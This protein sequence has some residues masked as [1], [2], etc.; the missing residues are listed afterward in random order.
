MEST[1]YHYSARP[2]RNPF[3][4]LRAVWRLVRNDPSTQIEEAAIVEM[5]F[6]NSRLGRRFARWEGVVD[7]L[8]ADPRTAPSFSTRKPFERI[9]LEDLERLPEG[10]LG[11]VFADHCRA[12]ELDPNLVYM[13]PNDDVGWL[14]HH[15][16]HTHDI[17]HVFT[18][19]GNDLPGEFGLGGFYAAQLGSPPFFGY[20]V[21]LLLLNVVMRRANLDEVLEAFS[22]GYQTG[23]RA[24]PLWGL[25][26]HELWDVPIGELRARFEIDRTA[27]VGEGV[28][29]AA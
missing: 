5:G 19:W 25:D 20:M 13:E 10:T 9:S 21:A 6:V 7:H 14:L 8:K 2:T 23:K 27:I 15:M 3:K 17:W 11:R 24:Q 4:Y 1:G 29:V 22:A 16:F 28:R 26:W 12:R 18:G